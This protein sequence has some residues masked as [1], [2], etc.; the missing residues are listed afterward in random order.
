MNKKE[1]PVKPSMEAGQWGWDPEIGMDLNLQAKWNIPETVF[2]KVAVCGGPIKRARNPHQPYTPDEIRTETMQSI[3][4]GAVCAHLH[5]RTDDGRPELDV[6]AL[7]KKYHLIIDPIREK[8]GNKVIMDVNVVMP[9]FED[10][11]T[12]MKSGL[13][14]LA[15]VNTSIESMVIPKKYVQAEVEAMQENGVKPEI[16]VYCDGDIDRA[17]AWLIDTGIIQKP[18]M[19]DLLPSYSRGGTPMFNEFSMAEALMWQVRQIR[20]IAPDSLIMVAGSGRPCSYLTTMA[21]LL[22]LDVKVGMEDTYFRWPH[23]DDVIE[24]NAKVVADTIAIA[25]ALGR[26]PATAAEARALLGMPKR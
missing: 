24:S 7:L 8:Y 12:V 14:E 18:L 2:V 19:W 26:R 25:K 1:I 17:K 3:E 22:G 21:M 13:V 5:A 4:A 23:K 20:H 6:N 16:A 15:P 11:V 9:K 10:E